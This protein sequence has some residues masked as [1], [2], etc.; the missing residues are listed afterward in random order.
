MQDSDFNQLFDIQI[1]NFMISNNL[2]ALD[3]SSNTKPR[4]ELG[5]FERHVFKATLATFQARKMSEIF[6]K[7]TRLKK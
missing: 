5:E 4:E 7:E 1:D 6:R 2:H 3:S